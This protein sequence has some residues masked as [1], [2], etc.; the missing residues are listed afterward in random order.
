MDESVLAAVI[1]LWEAK[2]DLS[3]LEQWLCKD[4]QVRYSR[5][6]VMSKMD[7]SAPY[8][9]SPSSSSSGVNTNKQ[10][11]FADSGFR[12]YLEICPRI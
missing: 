8:I 7:C 3:G 5:K 1:A 10:K 2:E 4:L 6:S 12:R 11:L 9:A